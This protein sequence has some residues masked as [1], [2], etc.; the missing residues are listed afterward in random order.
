MKWLRVLILLFWA[1]PAYAQN[2]QPYYPIDSVNPASQTYGSSAYPLQ[3]FDSI[4]LE[5]A[6]RWYEQCPGNQVSVTANASACLGTA[7]A[8]LTMTPAACVAYNQGLR[9]TETGSIVFPNSSTCWVAVDPN[10]SGTNAGL[11]N[12]GRVAGTHYL[13]DCIDVSAPSM[14][15]NAQLVMK[16]V[17]SGGSITG[18]TDERTKTANCG[19]GGGGNPG[20]VTSVTSAGNPIV[21]ANSTTTPVISF[22]DNIN[23]NQLINVAAATAAGNP[24][25]YLQNL[26]EIGDLLALN[27]GFNNGFRG[28]DNNRFNVQSYGAKGDGSADDTAAV[29]AAYDAAC[30]TTNDPSVT[31]IVYFPLGLY[32]MA[33]GTLEADCSSHGI[34][35]RGDSHFTSYIYANTYHPAINETATSAYSG[36]G[37]MSVASLIGATNTFMNFAQGS[38]PI[39]AW[40]ENLVM[41]MFPQSGY[42]PNPLNGLTGSAYTFYLKPPT[43]DANP[44][45]I[46]H[47]GNLDGDGIHATNQA[48]SI[49]YTGT[50]LT[51]AVRVGASRGAPNA[52]AT[53]TIASNTLVYIEVDEDCGGTGYIVVF[54]GT[55]GGSSSHG[56][57]VV[58]SGNILQELNEELDLAQSSPGSNQAGPNMQ[59]ALGDIR[60]EKAPLHTCPSGTCPTFTLPNT[61]YVADGN[62]L[63][64]GPTTAISHGGQIEGWNIAYPANTQIPVW[65]DGS[66]QDFPGDI[67]DLSVE[68]LGMGIFYQLRP[69]STIEHVDI[70]TGANVSFAGLMLYNNVYNAQVNQVQ[71]LNAGYYAYAEQ[72]D[73]FAYSNRLQMGS[74]LIDYFGA[75]AMLNDEI[76]IGGSA[77]I[78]PIEISTNQGVMVPNMIDTEI[79]PEGGYQGP[80]LFIG[81]GTFTELS[82]TGGTWSTGGGT[83]PVILLPLTSGQ[84]FNL[85]LRDIFFTGSTFSSG[86]PIISAGTPSG[87]LKVS[88]SNNSVGNSLGPPTRVQLVGSTLAADAF[89]DNIPCVGTH[90]M[91]GGTYTFT[92]D[93]VT[94][95]SACHVDWDSTTPANAATSYAAQ[96]SAGAVVLHG[97]GTDT[98]GFS[99]NG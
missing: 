25:I 16:V 46:L 99:C 91:T 53:G 89:V 37:T 61:D 36:L 12:F 13:T 43:V 48:L 74:A 44:H 3:L 51:A 14:P 66:Q 57:P 80:V 98:I 75:G 69:R 23:G 64:L 67:S 97:T 70:N 30:A 15:A 1:V 50:T 86:N 20:T 72:N 56:T 71:I 6:Q 4:D 58:C 11:P 8:G 54:Y 77:T 55:P 84:D 65:S 33:T 31:P 87:I 22:N 21:V 5:A 76:T 40:W 73:S 18:V 2:N 92:N 82:I 29:Q 45:T 19:G 79:D 41:P 49:S 78:I 10:T 93:C 26:G 83:N 96:P 32:R 38:Y 42:V 27:V 81:Q 62:T 39:G 47:S 60:I 28:Q 52:T 24:L 88:S 68:S 63:F 7:G 94:A 17:T 59:G 95:T 85:G 34:H 35:L 90:A 9:M